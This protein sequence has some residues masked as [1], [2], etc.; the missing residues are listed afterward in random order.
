MICLTNRL[1]EYLLVEWLDGLEKVLFIFLKE[2]PHSL[3]PRRRSSDIKAMAP[4]SFLLSF[5]LPLTSK[6]GER[7]Q[8]QLFLPELR[9]S[10]HPFPPKPKPNNDDQR[11]RL[12]G[13]EG[14]RRL[15]A[16]LEVLANLRFMKRSHSRCLS[17][18]GS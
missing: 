9:S 2:L 10:L 15:S 14:P 16:N 8:R 1:R 7:N 6:V 5:S 18:I 17:L 3:S 4:P 12:K 11:R 13:K